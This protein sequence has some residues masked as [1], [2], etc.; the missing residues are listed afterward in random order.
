MVNE[1]VFKSYNETNIDKNFLNR[2]KNIILFFHFF[3]IDAIFT[4]R[5]IG[6]NDR[7][8]LYMPL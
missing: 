3:E 7:M 5:L 8:Q 4:V 6:F 1:E 2:I